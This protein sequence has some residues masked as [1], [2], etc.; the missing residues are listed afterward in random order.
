MIVE[1]HADRRAGT[2]AARAPESRAASGPGCTATSSK[3]HR[4][5]LLQLQQHV[6]HRVA[7]LAAGQAD[8]HLVAVLDHPEVGDRLA[9]L[10]AQALG[11]L[12]RFVLALAWRVPLRD[13][14][15]FGEAQWRVQGKGGGIHQVAILA[16][17]ATPL[18]GIA[19]R[20]M[21]DA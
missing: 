13:R 19:S 4:R 14:S 17:M 15:G 8:H 11:E 16:G 7:V 5:L 10:V 18:P 12:V 20:V 2:R 6:E 9:D 1:R 3:R 21:L